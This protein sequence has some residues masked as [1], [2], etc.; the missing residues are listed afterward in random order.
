MR[1]QPVYL[2]SSAIVKRYVEEKGSDLWTRSTVN[3]R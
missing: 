3:Q 1:E 2:D